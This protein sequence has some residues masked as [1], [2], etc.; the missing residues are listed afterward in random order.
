MKHIYVTV[1]AT[2]C[3]TGRF[4]RTV[5]NSNYN[6]VSISFEPTLKE[7]YS[8][9]RRYK[10][11]PF[12]GGF[13]KESP[14]RYRHGGR[15]A[16]LL[17][18]KIPVSNDEYTYM[19]DR[20]KD[21]MKNNKDYVYNNLS[22]VMSL[23]HLKIKVKNSYTCVEFVSEQLKQLS[24]LRDRMTKDFYTVNSLKDALSPFLV[25]E[26]RFPVYRNDWG[27]DLFNKR[28]SVMDII[29]EELSDYRK[30]VTN[31][32]V[33]LYDEMPYVSGRKGCSRREA[34]RRRGKNAPLAS[35]K[36]DGNA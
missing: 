25:Y 8:F 18:F 4:I 15:R 11:T 23:L 33:T 13:V 14:R 21:F 31:L 36:G 9:A 32:V 19:L 10:S 30:L 35:E 6:H 20:I 5:T 3:F 7:L 1:T 27:D 34:C 16:K 12:C 22:A 29:G 26:G 24:S 17:L 2:P 28:L